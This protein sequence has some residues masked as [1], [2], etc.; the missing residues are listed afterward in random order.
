VTSFSFCESALAVG[1]TWHIRPLTSLGRKCGG[2]VDTLSLCGHVRPDWPGGWD[3]RS[4]DVDAASIRRVKCC[5][6]CAQAWEE[7]GG[8]E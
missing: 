3:I 2:G 1:Q 8:R 4:P 7:G 6:D 5:A